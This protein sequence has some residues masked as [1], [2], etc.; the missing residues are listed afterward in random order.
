MVQRLRICLPIPGTQ[1]PSLG[2]EDPTC[3]GTTK[4]MG[5]NF[6]DA[7]LLDGSCSTTRE[8][9]AV[10][11]LQTAPKRKPALAADGESPWAAK[12]TQ[13]SQEQQKDACH[14]ASTSDF[15]A[16]FRVGCRFS[17]RFLR[18]SQA[19]T[20][21]R[22]VGAGAGRE[23]DQRVWNMN[24]RSFLGL[25]LG[26]GCARRSSSGLVACCRLFAGLFCDC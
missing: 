23:A 19:I 7:P 12:K 11:S 24:L 2:Q 3:W 1:V 21:L 25:L 5:H 13:H 6:T 15:R 22:E 16:H 4:P 9:A 18:P 17:M 8:A 26:D 14:R 10:R 20:C